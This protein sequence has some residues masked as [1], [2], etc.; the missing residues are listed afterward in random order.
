MPNTL[1]LT[2]SSDAAQARLLAGI[3]DEDT[4]LFREE[5]TLFDFREGD[6]AEGA[7]EATKE[8]L[9]EIDRSLKGFEQ[10]ARTNTWLGEAGLNA[11]EH[12][13]QDADAARARGDRVGAVDLARFVVDAVYLDGGEVQGDVDDEVFRL[14]LPHPWTHGLDDLPGYDADTRLLA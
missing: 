10:A 8:L 1:G 4:K 11:E 7:D 14:R 5:P 3:M 13:L 6:E 9:E 2:T 12:L